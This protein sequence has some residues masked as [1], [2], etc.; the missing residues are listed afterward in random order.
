MLAD[1]A[2][3]YS[4]LSQPTFGELLRRWRRGRRLS[5]A[6]V[7][8]VLVPTVHNSTV[9]CWELGLKHP[10]HKYFTQLLRLTGIPPELALGL[11]QGEVDHS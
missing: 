4:N 5:Q 1:M 10:S 11:L 2:A 7:G 3:I 9:S 8:P 6:D